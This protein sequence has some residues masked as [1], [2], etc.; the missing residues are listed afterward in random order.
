MPSYPSDRIEKL[1]TAAGQSPDFAIRLLAELPAPERAEALRRWSAPRTEARVEARPG[2]KK[3][4]PLAAASSDGLGAQL[5]AFA[6][7]IGRV[8]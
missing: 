8:R 1:L 2:L 4:G 5:Q 7:T 3:C 6:R